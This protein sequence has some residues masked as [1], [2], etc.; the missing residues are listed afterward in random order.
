M[1][2]NIIIITNNLNSNN[3]I[4]NIKSNFYK[5]STIKPSDSEI[6]FY[7]ENNNN[8]IPIKNIILLNENINGKEMLIKK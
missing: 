8:N 4:I 3:N 7:P 2:I 1:L 5:Y 6:H